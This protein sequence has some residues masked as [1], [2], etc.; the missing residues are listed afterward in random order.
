V[1]D[2]RQGGRIA[3]LAF[4]VLLVAAGIGLSCCPARTRSIPL[5]SRK[6]LQLCRECLSPREQIFWGFPVDLN[7]A[8]AGDFELL[9]GIGPRRAEA[10]IRLR[11]EKGKIEDPD[12]LLV[13][14]GFSRRVIENLK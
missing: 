10:I 3:V 2:G 6:D 14:P 11:K 1:K 4:L 13:L 9:P 7:R 5:S 12:E 8:G